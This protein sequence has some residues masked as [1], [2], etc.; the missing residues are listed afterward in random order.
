MLAFAAAD[1]P[2]QY[3]DCVVGV[4]NKEEERRMRRRKRRKRWWWWRR[5]RRRSRPKRG[6]KHQLLACRSFVFRLNVLGV[7]HV[8]SDLPFTHTRTH[9][10]KLTHTQACVCHVLADLPL[11]IATMLKGS[12]LLTRIPVRVC[13]YVCVCV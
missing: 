3:F 13:V 5:I 2:F 10:H 11:E 7:C 4:T 1:S 9:T 12:V 8:L 6:L